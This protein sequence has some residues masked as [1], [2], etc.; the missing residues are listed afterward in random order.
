MSIL[1]E[2]PRNTCPCTFGMWAMV[3]V[4]HVPASKL[5]SSNPTPL[6]SLERGLKELW[7]IAVIMITNQNSMVPSPLS[8][9]SWVERTGEHWMSRQKW[10]KSFNKPWFTPSPVQVHKNTVEIMTCEYYWMENWTWASNMHS[11]PRKP[12]TV[13]WAAPKVA[14]HQGEGAPLLCSGESPLG[15]L[16]PALGSPAQERHWPLLE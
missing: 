2:N 14:R 6:L 13:P 5:P 9:Q 4:C 16:R 11:Q 8:V 12:T 3:H 15:A 1:M 7:A 10:Q